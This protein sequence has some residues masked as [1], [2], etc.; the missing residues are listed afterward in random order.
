RDYRAL[1]SEMYDATTGQTYQSYNGRLSVY[2][3]GDAWEGI[4]DIEARFLSLVINNAAECRGIAHAVQLHTNNQEPPSG[5]YR[6]VGNGFG[7]NRDTGSNFLFHVDNA[8]LVFGL[9]GSVQLRMNQVRAVQGATTQT[10]SGLTKVT[11]DREPVLVTDSTR[12]D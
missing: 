7:F 1:A 3:Q 12:P 10:V 11:F 4:S 8:Q 5:T 2:A 9:G 6:L